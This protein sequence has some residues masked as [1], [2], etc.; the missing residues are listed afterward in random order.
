[1]GSGQGSF[2]ISPPTHFIFSNARA[3]HNA[4]ILRTPA[5]H[6]WRAHL[7]HRVL[8]ARAYAHK[9][10]SPPSQPSTRRPSST[11]SA[12]WTPCPSRVFAIPFFGTEPS[13][14][15]QVAHDA[16][17]V[18]Q[19]PV[20]VSAAHDRLV[21]ALASRR[22]VAW[23][24]QVPTFA[25]LLLL[26]HRD[27]D[28]EAPAPGRG[29]GGGV[30]GP[31]GPAHAQPGRRRGGGGEGEEGPVPP[32]PLPLP[33]RRKG[34]LARLPHCRQ[35]RPSPAR[36]LRHRGQPRLQGRAPRLGALRLLGRPPAPRRSGRVR[37]V[38][39]GGPG[40]LGAVR[41]R[42][43]LRLQRRHP[44]RADGR[45][46]CGGGSGDG[47]R[48]GPSEPALPLPRRPALPLPRRPRHHRPHLCRPTDTSPHWTQRTRSARPL[49]Q[50]WMPPLPLLE[51]L[52]LPSH[53]LPPPSRAAQSS[54]ASTACAPS[55]PRPCPLSRRRV[56]PSSTPATA[57]RRTP[58]PH[59]LPS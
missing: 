47:G 6:V 43:P 19:P 12:P 39:R 1:M 57:P 52:P 35:G 14:L 33:R 24:P 23:A 13:A 8:P 2:E 41:P 50:S 54:T 58:L 9:C 20:S 5:H 38:R 56:W 16:G 30:C 18:V 40:R 25:L 59:P 29:G 31:G 10:R 48:G 11:P 46:R 49:R 26:L 55:P 34:L 7:H 22:R 32:A 28:K 45:G 4:R 37:R 53:R 17:L 21:A 42:P 15:P 44:A 51:T 27:D 3:S 36:F